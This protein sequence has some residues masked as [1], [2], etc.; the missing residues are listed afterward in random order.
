MIRVCDRRYYT[1][2]HLN[3]IK[4]KI[5]LDVNM[6]YNGQSKVFTGNF[7]RRAYVYLPTLPI[8]IYYIILKYT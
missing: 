7:R 1:F 6:L 8:V 3:A 5:L 2:V 4:E